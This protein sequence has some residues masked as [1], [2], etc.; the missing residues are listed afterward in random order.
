MPGQARLGASGSAVMTSGLSFRRVL[1]F[2]R[3][4]LNGTNL[5]V[6]LDFA[7]FFGSYKESVYFLNAHRWVWTRPKGDVFN[8]LAGP[9]AGTPFRHIIGIH[10]N[11]RNGIALRGPIK[12]RHARTLKAGRFKRDGIWIADIEVPVCGRST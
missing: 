8:Y 2:E 1:E 9:E 6:K 4:A 11:G 12:S 5:L 10:K 3:G 7:G